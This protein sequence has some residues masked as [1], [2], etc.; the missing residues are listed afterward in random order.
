MSIAKEKPPC[1]HGVADRI[2][3]S[4]TWKNIG[5]MATVRN[6]AQMEILWRL[7]RAYR[8]ALRRAIGAERYSR[9]LERKIRR[10]NKVRGK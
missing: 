7:R 10:K 6:W 5:L 4:C 8:R 1:P 9:Y 3:W 2:C